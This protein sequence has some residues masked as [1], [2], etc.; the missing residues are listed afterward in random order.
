MSF[1]LKNM[2]T[3]W[4]SEVIEMQSIGIRFKQRYLLPIMITLKDSW[5]DYKSLISYI[6]FFW[7]LIK[8][9]CKFEL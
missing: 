5:D 9:L 8:N 3:M 4:N 1:N 6:S 2:A 7:N